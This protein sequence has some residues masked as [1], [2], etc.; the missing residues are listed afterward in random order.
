MFTDTSDVSEV[1]PC[2]K[3]IRLFKNAQLQ[4]FGDRFEIHGESSSLTLHFDDISVV[5]VLGK[6]KLN[7]YHKDKLYQFKSGKRFNAL[8]YMNMYYHYNNL[9]GDSEH[10][11][12]LGL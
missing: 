4:L 7:I 1:I 8:K 11:Q 10:E 6:N 5:T 12:F 3:K 2:K 9:K